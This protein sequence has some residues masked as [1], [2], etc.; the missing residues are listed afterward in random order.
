MAKPDKSGLATILRYSQIGFIL[1]A[2]TVVGWLLGAA[3]DRWLGTKTIYIWGLLI[4][5]VAGFVELIRMS[6]R[7]EKEIDEI[8]KEEKEKD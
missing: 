6:I 7:S 2:A 1:P 5:I 4:G 8:E 3:L